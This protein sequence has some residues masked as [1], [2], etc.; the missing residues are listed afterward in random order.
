[1]LITVAALFV[2][3]PS[4]AS[5]PEAGI[6][7]NEASVA[8][9]PF[10]NNTGSQEMDHYGFG[11]ASE[12]R[13]QLAV[14]K[15]FDF[16]S[17]MQAT[18]VYKSSNESPQT[19]GRELGVTH[20]LSGMYQGGESNLQVTVELIEAGTGKLVWSLPYQSK[21]KDLFKLQASIANKVMEKFNGKSATRHVQSFNMK[22]YAEYIE[23]IKKANFRIMPKDRLRSIP[24]FENAIRL[25]STLLSAWVGLVENLAFHY[26]FIPNDTMVTLA[27]IEPLM[28]YIDTHFVESWETNYVKGVNSYWV[29]RDY[30]KGKQYFEE[31]L[32]ENPESSAA[33]S[34]LGAIYKRRLESRKALKFASKTALLENSGTSWSELGQ[35][36][37]SNGDFEGAETAFLKEIQENGVSAFGFYYDL[38]RNQGRLY[39]LPDVTKKAYNKIYQADLYIQER[40][41]QSLLEYLKVTKTDSNFNILYPPVYKAVAYAAL[42]KVDSAK[43]FARQYFMLHQRFPDLTQF[44]LRGLPPLIFNIMM[45]GILGDKEE[46]S[47]PIYFSANQLAQDKEARA[48]VEIFNI[49]NMALRGDYDGATQR[50][51]NLNKEIPEYGNYASL[52]SSPLLDRIKREYPLFQEAL[53]N[54]ILPP[55]A[56]EIDRLKM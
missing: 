39:E 31:V 17:A 13:T 42:N 49:W 48:D 11:L 56:T 8:I 35:I 53:D 3:F 15:Q 36:L 34:L 9:L 27:M 29:E 25:D 19:I 14:S 16:I 41:Y 4:G 10:F 22:A 47:H 7:A 55:K 26:W 52:R 38:M 6:S 12:I 21:Y 44:E 37:R 28:A 33:N 23:G 20:I 2:I 51:K 50:L 32:K 30:E 5:K 45:H 24:Y 18:M 46:I 40:D 43:F 54:I 1:M